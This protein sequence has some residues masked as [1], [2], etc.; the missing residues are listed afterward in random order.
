MDT[1]RGFLSGTVGK[2]KTVSDIRNNYCY[3]AVHLPFV[4]LLRVEMSHVMCKRTWYRCSRPNRVRGWEPLSHHSSPFFCWFTTWPGRII[5]G[6][7]FV[8]LGVFKNILKMDV[9]IWWCRAAYIYIH[10]WVAKYADVGSVNTAACWVDPLLQEIVVRSFGMI[11]VYGGSMYMLYYRTS[12][13]L[14]RIN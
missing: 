6:E 7:S 9:L 3:Y 12:K 13:V 2:F 4:P 14:F 8:G 11:C 5:H 1:S 10:S